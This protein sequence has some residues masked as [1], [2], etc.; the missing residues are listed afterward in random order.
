[1][2]KFRSYEDWFQHLEDLGVAPVTLRM[3][4]AAHERLE[5]NLEGMRKDVL[6]TLGELDTFQRIDSSSHVL[7]AHSLLISEDAIRLATLSDA[8]LEA[9][10]ALED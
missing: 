2:S 10:S 9:A 4:R 7:R 1:M 3:A 5:S 8:L 6:K